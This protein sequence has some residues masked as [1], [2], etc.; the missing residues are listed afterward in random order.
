MQ[1][2]DIDLIILFIVPE[3]IHIACGGGGDDRFALELLKQFNLAFDFSGFFELKFFRFH[4]HF[5]LQL[6]T[7]IV[8][9]AF[10]EM[11]G[12]LDPFSIHFFSHSLA[13]PAA[14]MQMVF[15]AYTYL[16]FLDG[17][18]R[19]WYITGSYR[20]EFMDKLQHQINGISKTVGT[21]IL[22]V[23]LVDRSCFED[24]GVGF[25]RDTDGRIGFPVLE[26]DVIMRLILLDE[27]VFQQ[28]CILLTIYHHVPYI[29]DMGHKL[30]GFGR[31][32]ILVEIAIHPS[33]QVLCL[34]DIDNLS[35][36][37]EVLVHTGTL[38]YALQ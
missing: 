19:K 24:P 29:S 7:D 18:G 28:E 4:P 1:H 33:V 27:V 17:I 31:L 9:I 6:L 25:T 14:V 26:Q 23:F 30:A 34:T 3:D 32:M 10:D 2:G 12:L 15:K 35:L 5:L 16:F 38:R 22:A 8:C 11:S 37:I 36:F 13:D 20:I 21:V